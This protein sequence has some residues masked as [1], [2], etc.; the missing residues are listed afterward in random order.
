[1]FSPHDFSPTS[2]KPLLVILIRSSSRWRNIYTLYMAQKKRGQ[3]SFSQV[4]HM[5]QSYRTTLNLRPLLLHAESYKERKYTNQRHERF[6]YTQFWRP[7]ADVSA[8]IHVI[9]FFSAFYSLIIGIPV[10]KKYLIVN[11]KYVLYSWK[12]YGSV[13]TDF[14]RNVIDVIAIADDPLPNATR[15]RR[16]KNSKPREPR[17]RCVR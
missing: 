12:K 16:I 13:H 1:M 11:I 3:V 2:S 7:D 5:A 9:K 17:A 6:G 8:F 15:E 4:S 10:R 14:S